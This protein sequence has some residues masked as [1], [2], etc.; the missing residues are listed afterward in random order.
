MTFCLSGGVV[1][2][3]FFTLYTCMERVSE[4]AELRRRWLC[5][6]LTSPGGVGAPKA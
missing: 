5:R 2:W 6:Y 1:G 3:Q 4:Q